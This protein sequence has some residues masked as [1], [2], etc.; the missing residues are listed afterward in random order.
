MK[1]LLLFSFLL[2][3]LSALAVPVAVR[4]TDEAG[5]PIEGA[6]VQV[7][8]FDEGAPP[9]ALETTDAQGFARYDLG[10]AKWSADFFGRAVAWKSGF[11][12]GGVDLNDLKNGEIVLKLRAGQSV[13]GT[14]ED[15]KGPVAGALITLDFASADSG[16]LYDFSLSA[17]SPLAQKSGARSD[18]QGRFTL[19]DVPTGAQLGLRVTGEKYASQTVYAKSGD[20][21]IKVNLR[22]GAN[23]RGQLLATDGAPLAGVEVFALDKKGKP[24]ASSAQSTTDAGGNYLLSGLEGGTYNVLYLPA[25][26][27]AYVIAARQGAVAVAGQTRELETARAVPGVVVRGRVINAASKAGVGGMSVVVYGPAQPASSEAVRALTTDENGNFSARVAPG[28][29]R[30]TVE[31]M[32]ADWDSS[33]S[34]ISLDVGPGGAD[35]DATIEIA[36]TVPL[37]GRIV[38]EAG[39]VVQTKLAITQNRREQPLESDENGDFT[40]YGLNKGEATIGRLKFDFEDEPVPS[41][42][43]I[44]REQ[45][46]VLPSTEPLQIVVRRTQFGALSGLVQDENGAP[47]EGVKLNVSV[48]N[49]K[50]V[51]STSTWPTILSDA[52]GRFSLPNIRAD[53]T[54]ELRGIEKTGYDLQRGGEISKNGDNWNVQPVQMRARRSQLAGHVTLADGAPAKDALVFAAG[55]ETRADETGAYLLTVLPQGNV[56]IL[57]YADGQFGFSSA[58]TA[59]PGDAAT[60]TDLKLA[61]QTLQ[62]TDRDLAGEMLARA[63]VLAA[64]TNPDNFGRL[65]L[66]AADPVAALESSIAAPNDEQLASAI[67]R[68]AGNSD[69]ST[70]LLLRAVRAISD[71][72]WRLYAATTLFAKRPDWPDDA[73]TR[74]LADALLR[75]AQ[76]I[77]ADE[78]VS[79]KWASA[80]GL[81]G[82]APLAERYQGEEAGAAALARAIAWVKTR[83]PQPGN[84]NTDGYLS[85]FAATA[86]LV[87]ANSSALFVQLLKAIDDPTSPAYG[88]ALQQGIVAMA[89]TRGLEA[90]APFLRQFDPQQY[91]PGDNDATNYA[92]RQTARRAIE[93]G[94]AGA[95]A[96]A[97]E[98][99]RGLGASNNDMENESARALAQAAFFQPP[100]VAAS[101]WKEAVPQLSADRAA[102]IAVRVAQTQ[103]VLGAELLEIARQKLESDDDGINSW[104]SSVVAAFAFY[105][106]KSDAARARYRLEKAWWQA[107]QTTDDYRI[108]PDLVRAMATIDGE[109]A[110]EWAMLLPAGD[111]DE[112]VWALSLAARYIEAGARARGR[113][114]F[115]RWK[116]DSTVFMD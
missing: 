35:L 63:R 17:D 46:V 49:G 52:Q 89:E 64:Q 79:N 47:I 102:Q 96:L 30:F 26:D 51:G 57:V 65:E 48:A 111:Y 67:Y 103:P 105:E 25:P 84:G 74:A 70:E 8:R 2:A 53:Q 3:P 16:H 33:G 6:T 5:A 59:L 86:E 80:I 50:G 95:P 115:E 45:T 73:Q 20:A 28:A 93:E 69:V 56:D 4:V 58:Q 71:A 36:R 92:A 107:Q 90:A 94:G 116:R 40:I 55:S 27:A 109:R 112:R 72:R 77:A 91:G 110:F 62:P 19:N 101:L 42:W 14:V 82:A 78:N 41:P 99:A 24:N 43:E 76:A 108:R 32:S 39:N 21:A 113:V 18:A 98:L 34:A 37:R 9:Y 12:L 29:N 60:P 75:D 88:R 97:L 68:G 23:L 66:S 15:A 38:D 22:L 85:T 87:A 83:D 100:A 81:L 13:S 11:A 10:A 61:L 7:K 54:V 31:V 1:S 44:A 114:D 106:A 104:G